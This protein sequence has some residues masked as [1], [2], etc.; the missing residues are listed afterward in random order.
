M[1][2][3]EKNTDLNE[4]QRRIAVYEDEAAYKELFFRLYSP[5]KKFSVGFLRSA[6]IAEEVVSD[7]FMEIWRRRTGLMEI[8]DLKVYMY[9]CVR[10]AS[11]KKLQQSRKDAI[12]SLDDF[13]YEFTSSYISA[14]EAILT[15]ELHQKIQS[16]INELPPRC[17]LVY[18]LA[19]EDKLPYKD[20]SAILNISVKT[21]DNQLATA[22]KKIASAINF[23]LKR[24]FIV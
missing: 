11:L 6:E 10:N 22:L 15:S 19:K 17:K 23:R 24:N 4:L 7:V 2:N 3:A 12:V 13:S 20:I 21:V 9:I 18:K 8:E 16:V 1:Q 5:L 14:E